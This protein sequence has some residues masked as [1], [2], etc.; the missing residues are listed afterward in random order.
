MQEP[1]EALTTVEKAKETWLQS[2]GA[3]VGGSR[4]ADTGSGGT[5]A[6]RRA[7]HLVT[8]VGEGLPFQH[9]S[10]GPAHHLWVDTPRIRKPDGGN[11]A[12]PEVVS[13]L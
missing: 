11:H 8:R 3:V 9:V 5:V 1:Q 13:L 7:A 10:H 6:G 4:R 2:V 12:Q